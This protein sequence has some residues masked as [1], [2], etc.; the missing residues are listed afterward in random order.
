[1][2]T[3]N[4]MQLFDTA[5][6]ELK[7]LVLHKDAATIYVCGITPYDAAH[8]GHMFTFL[9]YDLIARRLEDLGHTVKL[10]RNVTDVDD[11]LFAKA[12][13]LGI[14]YQQLATQ[15][16]SRLQYVTE[17]LNFMP[18]FAEPKA[19]EYVADM[20]Q[21]VKQ[22]LDQGI[23][24]Q[25]Q[26]DVYFD[27]SQQPEFGRFSNFSHRLQLAFMANRGGDPD[28]PGKRNPLDFLLWRGVSDPDD[29]AVWDTPWKSPT[30][31]GR[32]GWH[33]ECSI[34]SAQTLGTPLTLHGGG[35]DL[36]FPHHE[37]EIA[38][39]R[40]LG[41]QPL[42]QHWAHVAPLLYQGEKMSKSLGNL[43]FAHSLLEQHQPAVVRLALMQLHY[44]TGGEWRHDSLHA[45]GALAKLLEQ[46]LA[47]KFQLSGT[48]FLTRIRNGLDNDLDTH[49]VLHVLHTVAKETLALTAKSRDAVPLDS[50][51]ANTQLRRIVHLLGLLGKDG[52]LI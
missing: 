22:L 19:S 41:H 28:R 20:A 32:P 14:S 51:D 26:N 47:H 24:Y 25:L 45:A 49:C 48:T 36:I 23:A 21:A 1:M 31:Q 12:A 52:Q 27:S 3:F 50:T 37:C 17:Q 4:V 29:P 18:L 38:Q 30:K 13:E 5:S 42:A 46:A 16:T 43:V 15:E 39:S 2:Y 9:T 44:R 10:V 7:P 34:M 35:M 33:I 40:A 11:P 8:L 6:Q